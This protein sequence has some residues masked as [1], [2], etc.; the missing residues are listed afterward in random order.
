MAAS[1]GVNFSEYKREQ[2]S[3]MM[4]DNPEMTK[5]EI[6]PLTTSFGIS[7]IPPKFSVQNATPDELA[8]LKRTYPSKILFKREV[9]NLNQAHQAI[10]MFR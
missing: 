4:K 6:G 2:M 8:E 3:Q 5:E 1:S 7:L 10:D 9:A